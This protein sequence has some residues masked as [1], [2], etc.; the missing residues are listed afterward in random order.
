MFDENRIKNVQNKR[1]KPHWLWNRIAREWFVPV[2]AEC[3]R[4]KYTSKKSSWR[5]TGWKAPWGTCHLR[6]FIWTLLYQN[7]RAHTRFVFTAR[8]ETSSAADTHATTVNRK[9]VRFRVCESIYNA[10]KYYIIL[11][12][13]GIEKDKRKKIY[14]L[15]C[16][17]ENG[18][19]NKFCPGRANKTFFLYTYPIS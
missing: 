14:R 3:M 16:T 2:L 4:E 6:R 18:D 13:I 10:I 19:E 1:K 11:L 12:Y 17:H 7:P 9:T 8:T 15:W 5:R